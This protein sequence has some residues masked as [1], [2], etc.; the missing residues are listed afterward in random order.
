MPIP[1]LL[2]PLAKT[3]ARTMEPTFSRMYRKA[4]DSAPNWMLQAL[5]LAT[6]RHKPH[7]ETLARIVDTVDISSDKAIIECGVFRGATLLGMAHRLR[8]RGIRECRLIG[9]D[10]FEGLPD[11]TGEDALDG[12]SFHPRA[13]RGSYYGSYEMLSHR[14]E[15]LGYRSWIELKRGYFEDV[16]PGMEEENYIVAHLDCDLYQS[17]ITCLEHVYPRMIPGGY[18]VFDEYSHSLSVFPGAQRAIDEFFSDKPEKPERFSDVE[19]P[20]Y[21]VKKR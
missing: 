15:N 12:G 11:P 16:L 20:R 14:V 10:S 13:S 18:I 4:P 1:K 9:C 17:Y 6:P 3:T 21:F 8:L 19:V 5:D 2:R 7:F